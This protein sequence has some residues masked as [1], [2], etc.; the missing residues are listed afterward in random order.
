MTSNLK[1]FTYDDD[2]VRETLDASTT[3][4]IVW[5]P[6]NPFT[7]ITTWAERKPAIL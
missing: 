5:M 2:I 4:S 1:T 6:I 7:L 3:R